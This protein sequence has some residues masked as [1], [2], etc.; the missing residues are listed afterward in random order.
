MLIS[1]LLRKTVPLVLFVAWG[2]GNQGPDRAVAQTAAT[3]VV[4][5]QANACA[6]HDLPATTCFICDPGLRDPDRLWCAGHE[7]YE[8]RCFLCHPELEEPGRV[9]CSEHS[10]YEDEC[11]LCHPE[12]RE[13][14]PAETIETAGLYCREHGVPES[15]C[16]ICHPELAA[17]LEPGSGL[18]IRFESV[19]STSLAGVVTATPVVGPQRS[20]STFLARVTWDENHYAGVTPLAAGVL[21][22]VTADVGQRVSRGD[23]LATLSSPEIAEIKSAYLSAR[24]EE[25]LHLTILTRQQSLVEQRIS[26]QQD[27]DQAEAEYEVAKSRAAAARQL[28]LEH[29][30]G[31]GAIHNLV[32]TGTPASNLDVVAPLDGTIV[33]RH[34]V[35]GESMWLELS[36]PE[37]HVSQ[38]SADQEVVA[39]F[40]LQPG[41]RAEGSIIWVGSSI[42]SDSRMVTARAEVANP[43]RQLRHGMFG[44]ARI[45][46]AGV[47]G[48]TVWVPGDAVQYIDEQPFV[49]ARLEDDLFELRRITVGGSSGRMVAVAEGLESNAEIVV[50]HSFTLKSEF[51]KSRLGAGCVEH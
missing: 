4:V 21:R 8:D 7:R 36:I 10:L 22:E 1:E 49:F 41:L 29:G 11:F 39:T 35:V 37:R 15:D 45:G 18:K 40:D 2:C 48:K 20:D 9:W 28:L 50:A 44:R 42:D 31:E 3:S 6:R 43:D 13:T 19:R 25:K 26:A 51:L 34:A 24:A 33:D 38:V 46:S 12:L 47:S 27:L 5:E 17:D 16:G 32:E 23:R 30:V 14:T